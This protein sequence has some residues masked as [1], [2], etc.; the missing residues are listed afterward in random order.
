LG[1]RPTAVILGMARNNRKITADKL[2][3]F[4]QVTLVRLDDILAQSGVE[5]QI[6]PIERTV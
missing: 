2:F 5:L 1:D 6:A 3:S 4:T